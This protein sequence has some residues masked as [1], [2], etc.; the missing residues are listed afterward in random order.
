MRPFLLASLLLS[1]PLCAGAQ[2]SAPPSTAPSEWSLGAGA[3]LGLSLGRGSSLFAS[4]SAP[5]SVFLP[6]VVASLERRVGERSWL[7]LAVY[8]TA[9][10]DRQDVP[11]GSFGFEKDDVRSLSIQCGGRFPVTRPGAPVEVSL[12][13]AANLGAAWRS[14]RVVGTTLP[15]DQKARAWLVGAEL[16]LAVDRDLTSGLALRVATP[17]TALTWSE[18]RGEARGEP[19]LTGRT[20]S[21]ALVLVPRL[22]LRLAF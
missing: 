15:P 17:L 1:A 14:S 18:S 2:V 13:A 7:T 9:S 11:S 10:N 20:W 3:T 5:V 4:T 22:E 19:A 16:G 8:G 6:S 21:A 12:L